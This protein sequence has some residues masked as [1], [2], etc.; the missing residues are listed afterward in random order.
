MTQWRRT[1]KT[2]L[3]TDQKMIKTRHK[4]IKMQ[5][6]HKIIN[7]NKLTKWQQWYTLTKLKKTHKATNKQLKLGHKNIK[8]K[9]KVTKMG[10]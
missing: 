10:A 6:W 9:H 8:L 1:T 4:R 7:E 2:V 3:H 5:D